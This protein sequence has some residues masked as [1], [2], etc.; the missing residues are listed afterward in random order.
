MAIIGLRNSTDV[1]NPAGNNRPGQWRNMLLRLYPYGQQMAPLAALTAVMKSEATSDP[2]YHWFR[3]VSNTHRFQLAANLSGGDASGTQQNVTIDPAQGNAYGVKAGDVLMVEQTGELLYVVQTPTTDSQ[4]AVLRGFENAASQAVT[5][6]AININPWL[7][8]IGSAFEEGSAAPDPIGWDPEEASNQTQIF[9]ETYGMTGTGMAT[10]TRT[11]DVIRE[12]KQDCFEA[13]NVGMEMAFIFGKKRT[14]A[15]NNQPLR[16]TDGVLNMLPADRKIS[17]TTYDANGLISMAYWETLFATMFRYGSSE[18]MAFCGVSAMLA[19]TQAVRLNSTLQWEL[20]PT[21]KEYGMDIRRIRTPMGT[22]VLKIHPIFGQ[23]TG[24][25]NPVGGGFFPGLDNAMLIMDMA[26]TRY[27]YLR[28]RDV[29]Y[30][31]NLQL[32]GVDGL[33][34]GYM[35]ECGLELHHPETHLF[36]TGIRGGKKDP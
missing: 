36:L 20:G 24:G 31:T 4:I 6:N 28:G 17:V 1:G 2:I 3:R 27:R 21:E 11:G 5:W 18:K 25:A 32:P 12:N 29:T 9:R 14:T 26:N 13:F 7:K 22:L 19:V 35:G 30:Q 23:M 10:V 8:K 33:L 34:A 15:R 16:M